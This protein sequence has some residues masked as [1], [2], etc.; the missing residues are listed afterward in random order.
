MSKNRLNIAL[1]CIGG[2]LSR[3]N[4]AHCEHAGDLGLAASEVETA[5]LQSAFS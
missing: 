3:S 4:V 5:C 1:V 2:T